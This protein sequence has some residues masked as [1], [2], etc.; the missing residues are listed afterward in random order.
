MCA[1]S[2]LKEAIHAL[3]FWYCFGCMK[4]LN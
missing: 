1:N 2:Q 4:D 3:L